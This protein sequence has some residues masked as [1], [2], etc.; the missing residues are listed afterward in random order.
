MKF[1]QFTSVTMMAALMLITTG[2]Q[3]NATST[4]SKEVDKIIEKEILQYSTVYKIEKKKDSERENAKLNLT[5]YTKELNKVLNE[6]AKLD[7]LKV[8]K[9][10]LNKYP[11]FPVDFV[12]SEDLE[13]IAKAKEAE[14]KA[15]EQKEDIEKKQ[16]EERKRL[17][18][19]KRKKEEAERK[20]KEE[21]RRRAQSQ[22]NQSSQSSP[23]RTSSGGGGSSQSRPRPQSKPR[24]QQSSGYRR[25]GWM[26]QLINSYPEPARRG[27]K[28][29]RIV[30][31]LGGNYAGMTYTADMRIEIANWIKDNTFRGTV[32]HEIGHI[33]HLRTGLDQT[34]EWI[35]IYNAEWAGKGYY[36]SNNPMEAFADTFKSIYEPGSWGARP[37]SQ[38]PRSVSF[39]KKHLNSGI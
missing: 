11:E 27:L 34:Q 35:D 33:Y 31:S 5:K 23:G 18:E 6:I 2:T 21:E 1:K 3:A 9:K 16:E 4:N 36:G 26:W 20:R 30:D 15:K 10:T 37:T 12:K 19:E 39:M 29:A 28:G 22:R 13:L 24:P 38:I 32:A 8:D 14:M 17:E 25:E 7:P